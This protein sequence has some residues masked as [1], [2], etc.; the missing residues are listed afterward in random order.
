MVLLSM[1]LGIAEGRRVILPR[2]ADSAVNVFYA[3]DKYCFPKILSVSGAALMR[4]D[5]LAGFADL[6]LA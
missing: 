5:G 4:K 3:H 6:R 1:F 2:I